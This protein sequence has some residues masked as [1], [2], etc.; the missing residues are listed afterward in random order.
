MALVQDPLSVKGI[1]KKISTDYVGLGLIVLG[2]GCFQIMLDKGQ[3][4][5]WFSSPFICWMAAFAAIGVFG[6]LLM[7]AWRVFLAC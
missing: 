1:R 3:D 7:M 4:A 5:D 6:H 2:L